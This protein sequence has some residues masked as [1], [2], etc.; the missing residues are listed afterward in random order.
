MNMLGIKVQVFLFIETP[1]GIGFTKTPNR[2]TYF[3][4]IIQAVIKLYKIFFTYLKNIK[5]MIFILVDNHM[6]EFI[7][8]CYSRHFQKKKEQLMLKLLSILYL[9]IQSVKNI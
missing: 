6:M 4:D 1:T 8:P 7:Y 2:T 9:M 3:N 5:Q